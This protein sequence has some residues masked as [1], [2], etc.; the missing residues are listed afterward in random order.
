MTTAPIDRPRRFL[1]VG[2]L[3]WLLLSTLSVSWALATPIAAAPDEPA[4]L[5]KAAS[6]AF[7]QVAGGEHTPYGDL[8]DVPYWVAYTHAQ[9]C[10]AFEPETSADCAPDDSDDDTT[11]PALTTAGR[12]NATYYLLVGWPSLF[13][14]DQ[15]GVYAMRVVSALIV[16]LVAAIGIGLL[17]TWRAPAL[18]LTG[19]LV[20]TTPMVL[21][22]GGV[23]NPNGLENATVFTAFVG[24]LTVIVEH[25]RGRWLSF[26]AITVAVISAIGV[27]IRGL[28]ALWFAIALLA[29]FLLVRRERLIELVRHRAIQ[30]AAVTIVGAL[31]IAFGWLTFSNSL[32][33]GLDTPPPGTPGVGESPANGFI[34]TL[35]ATFEY[36][37]GLIGIFGWLDTPSPPGTLAIWAALV[38]TLLILAGMLL[39]RRRMLFVVTLGILMLLI[40]PILQAAYITRGGIIWQGRYALP[41]FICLVVG[42]ACVLADRVRLSSRIVKRLTVIVGA[43]WVIGQGLAFA[44]AMRR[45]A[46]GLSEGWLSLLDPDWEPPGGVILWLAV[47]SLGFTVAGVAYVT[48]TM[49]P[50]VAVA[51]AAPA[52]VVSA[53]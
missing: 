10:F 13:A 9:T 33:A 35:M 19:A 20:A 30:L 18:P 7:G 51:E 8:V 46:S 5:V 11:T 45:Y 14:E 49:L 37:Q 36:D 24:V 22:L 28:S 42:A 25:A 6:V 16:S 53:S 29:P 21:F 52:A 17:A 50:R 12:Y 39:R 31:A 15:S 48:A 34:W 27:N 2:A 44:T 4:H 38:G 40:P 3:A 41:L 47:A 32:G 43:L 23:V 26:I 1:V